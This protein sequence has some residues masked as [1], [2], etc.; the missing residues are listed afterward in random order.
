[1]KGRMFNDRNVGILVETETKLKGEDN[2]VGGRVSTITSG[3]GKKGRAG[4]R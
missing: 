1:M 4:E 2:V 3:N